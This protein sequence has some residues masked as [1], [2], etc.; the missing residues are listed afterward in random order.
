M[1]PG[2]SRVTFRA[3]GAQPG[4]RSR[5]FGEPHCP[6]CSAGEEIAN[7]GTCG[8]TV[9]AAKRGGHLGGSLDLRLSDCCGM[10]HSRGRAG[11][12]D[13]PRVGLVVTFGWSLAS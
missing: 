3:A 6:G 1:L 7:V 10:D 11:M 13:P 8:Q 9:E 5:Q 4:N 2:D 12:E